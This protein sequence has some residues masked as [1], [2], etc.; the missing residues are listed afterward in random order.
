MGDSAIA[1]LPLSR[2]A[3]SSERSRRRTP[4]VHELRDG[5]A[6]AATLWNTAPD[7]ALLD[8]AN[9]DGLAR[10]KRFARRPSACSGSRK[11]QAISA[12]FEDLYGTD[13]L[14]NVFKDAAIFPA[15]QTT[16]RDAM[17]EELHLRLDDM[18]FTPAAIFCRSTTA[19]AC[20]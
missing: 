14:L 5:V 12:F 20:S 17:L 8:A 7:E 18:V 4:Q 19:R 11:P 3:R 1:E 6:L 9:N 2:R 16:L 15:W 10:P 13:R